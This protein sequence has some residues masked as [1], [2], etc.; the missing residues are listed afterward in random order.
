MKQCVV[1]CQTLRDELEYVLGTLGNKPDV[2]WIESGLHN[3]PKKLRRRLQETLDGVDGYD[4]VF[5][6]FGLCGNAVLGLTAG[7]FHMIIP[8]VDDCISLLIGSQAQR[9]KLAR[10]KA[11]YFLT[12][13]WLR[14]ERNI[15]VEYQYS[16]QKYG[17]ETAD[18]IAKTMYGHYKALGLLDTP[19]APIEQLVEKTKMIS[20]TFGL[21]Q[22]VLPATTQY[23]KELFSGVWPTE[24]F[25]VIQPRGT[26]HETDFLL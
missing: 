9:D 26:V 18:D 4:H 24:K 2:I 11:A 8:K 16:I 5:L 12:D 10:E 22:I 6:L 3:A 17:K 1:A 23:I 20:E 25:V 21:E 13:G 14:G 19:A 7:N 15:W